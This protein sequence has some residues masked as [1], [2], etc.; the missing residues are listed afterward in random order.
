MWVSRCSWVATAPRTSAS[1]CPTPPVTV[2]TGGRHHGC[3]P[4][5]GALPSFLHD[6]GRS[7]FS[8]TPSQVLRSLGYI[9]HSGAVELKGSVARQISNHELLLTQLLLDNTLTDLRPEEIVALLSCTVCQVRTQVEP[10]LPSVLQK[11]R[12]CD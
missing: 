9:N 4:L 7:T 8:P 6:C 12:V 1:V 10:Q 11:V 5:A 2:G 3:T